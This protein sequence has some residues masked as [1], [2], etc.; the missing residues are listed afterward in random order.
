M[1]VALPPKNTT[2]SNKVAPVQTQPASPDNDVPPPPSASPPPEAIQQ[3]QRRLSQ[4]VPPARTASPARSPPTATPPPNVDV[5]CRA[6]VLRFVIDL[7]LLFVVVEQNGRSHTSSV[8][9]G[10]GRRVACCLAE[11]KAARRHT[12][13]SDT[14]CTQLTCPANAHA[15]TA[16]GSRSTWCTLSFHNTFTLVC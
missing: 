3:H 4:R 1:G 10:Y 5:R 11:T 15:A 16:A 7:S 8:R 2:T 12:D 14:C 9:H 13:T 6:C